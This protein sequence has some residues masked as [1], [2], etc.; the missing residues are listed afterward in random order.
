MS[1]LALLRTDD[2]TGGLNLRADPF[3]LADN[4]SPDMLNVD[5]DPRGGF[6]SRGGWQVVNTTAI[7]GAGTPTMKGIMS[8]DTA[9][10]Q[11]LVSAGTG[12]WYSSTLATF[13]DTTITTSAMDGASFAPW[14]GASRFVYMATGG[15][16]QGAKWSGS[17]KTLLTASGTSAWQ[18]SFA[19]PTGTHMPKAEHAAVHSGRLWVANTTEDSTNYPDRV[20]FSH[21]N[22]P[23]SWR[24]ADYI[25]V[26]GGG[27]GITA[28]IPFG[29]SLMVFKKHSIWIITGYSTD[30]FQLVEITQKVGVTSRRH[31]ALAE[32]AVFFLSWPDGL[33][34][35]DGSQINYMFERLRPLL[36]DGS[37]NGATIGR[38]AVAFINRRVWVSLP[39]VGYTNPSVTYVLDPTL[40]SGG[41]W[42]RYRGGTTSLGAGVGCDHVLSDGSVYSIMMPYGLDAIVRIDNPTRSTDY[43]T[44]GAG[45]PEVSYQSYYV[46]RWH[47][48]GSVSQRKMWRRPDMIVSEPSVA[49]T[50]TVTA[51]H[52]WREGLVKRSSQVAIPSAVTGMSWAATATE[53]DANAGWG[54]AVWGAS[55]TGDLYERGAN[56]GLARSIQLKIV[57]EA[58]KRWG[59][60]SITYKYNPRKVRA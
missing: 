12:V 44:I 38:A 58:G 9:T 17:A 42:V 55:A 13:T 48:A 16:T 32:G 33:L 41:S 53:P 8:W 5:V 52:D 49:T 40:N 10:P 15:S 29:G 4:E 3:Q 37:I 27:V 47:D 36:T 59:V 24:S 34:M 30:T 14:T 54:E 45:G 1:R 28:L 19:S 57:G 7:S 25:D 51:F 31:I 39:E 21:P 23:E 18:E 20:R 56:I 2:F 60:S 50:L 26:V 22:F 35:F 46:T 11:V 43:L 6:S